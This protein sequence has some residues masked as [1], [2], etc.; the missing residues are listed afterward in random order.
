MVAFYNI[1]LYSNIYNFNYRNFQSGFKSKTRLKIRQ[2]KSCH[3]SIERQDRETSPK[4]QSHFSPT[5]NGF[6]FLFS[7]EPEANSE[8]LTPLGVE[9]FEK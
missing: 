4:R 6:F 1:R 2:D 9:G 3:I 5:Y 8:V 7:I